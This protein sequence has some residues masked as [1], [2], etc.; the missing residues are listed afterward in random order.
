MGNY[1]IKSSSFKK[2]RNKEKFFTGSEKLI[3]NQISESI[4]KIELQES[5]SNKPLAKIH[6]FNQA[7]FIKSSASVRMDTSNQRIIR[8]L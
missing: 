2:Q 4:Y 8:E 7:H 6:I 5:F 3:F 1:F